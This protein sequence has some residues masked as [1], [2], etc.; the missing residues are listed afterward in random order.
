VAKFFQNILLPGSSLAEE[1][2]LWYQLQEIT[3]LFSVGKHLLIRAHPLPIEA[4][5]AARLRY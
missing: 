1:P 3:P 2:R 5:L 4:N